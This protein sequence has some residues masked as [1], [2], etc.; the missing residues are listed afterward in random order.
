[1]QMVR[2]CYRS[3]YYSS[4]FYFKEWVQSV[5]KKVHIVGWRGASSLLRISP[6]VLSG[7][8]FFVSLSPGI[9]LLWTW[10]KSYPSTCT[11]LHAHYWHF[12]SF[13]LILI[14]LWCSNM[15]KFEFPP[16]DGTTRIPWSITSRCRTFL[17]YDAHEFALVS[18]HIF[19]AVCSLSSKLR[20][21]W[22]HR[23][24]KNSL[25]G[26]CLPLYTTSTL[27]CHT[28]KRADSSFAYQHFPAAS[29]LLVIN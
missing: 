23:W 8:L 25:A 14:R 28:T 2:T 27:P 29:W 7:C 3:P 13:I 15:V 24:C 1:M 10:K 12:S 9:S 4:Y 5:S 19:S 20:Y 16:G 21:V 22:A 18:Y 17:T 26:C 6:F 11:K